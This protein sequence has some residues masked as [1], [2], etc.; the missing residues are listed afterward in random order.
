MGDRSSS[1][2][3]PA[4]CTA[5]VKEYY[6]SYAEDGVAHETP[7]LPDAALL[8]L[9]AFK[10][11]DLYV[12]SRV[13]V[14]DHFLGKLKLHVDGIRG[15]L[16]TGAFLKAVIKKACPAPDDRH[17]FYN[18]A[19][20]EPK[21]AVICG[22]YVLS[23]PDGA[24]F[25]D[26]AWV[27]SCRLACVAE[28]QVHVPVNGNGGNNASGSD[29]LRDPS[30]HAGTVASARSQSTAALVRDLAKERRLVALLMAQLNGNMPADR[31]Q[32]EAVHEFLLQSGD[33]T[34]LL[35]SAATK[36]NLLPVRKQYPTI[37][38]AANAIAFY[39]NL[40]VITDQSRALVKALSVY[41]DYLKG[42]KLDHKK[43]PEQSTV[44][45]V[46]FAD[47]LKRMFEYQGVDNNVERVAAKDMALSLLPP[48]MS[49]RVLDTK[50]SRGDGEYRAK[51]P[52]RGGGFQAGGP[53]Y[54]PRGGQPFRGNAKRKCHVCKRDSY[55]NGRCS[56]QSCNRNARPRGRDWR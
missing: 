36:A 56:N 17:I 43:V 27:N 55:A 12:M 52:A 13:P 44:L 22:L 19:R 18:N 26:R 14:A 54:P 33:G 21:I 48:T 16:S 34:G 25:P 41:V 23:K 38:T 1:Y 39:E 3:V 40:S 6:D 51:R 10:A 5:I 37:T 7:A 42:S 46:L 9:T 30:T 31:D 8:P 28:A 4:A 32:Q 53:R 15:D 47:V 29:A 35:A 49:A 24:K 45:D 50:H 11:V 20:L 2:V